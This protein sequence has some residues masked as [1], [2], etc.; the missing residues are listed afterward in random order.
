MA[1]N[2]FIC[3]HGH[4]YQ[5]PRENAW[6][7][8]IESQESAAPYHDWNSRIQDECYATNAAARVVDD[9]SQILDI[10]NNYKRISF[11][12]GP[13]LL[14]WMQESDPITYRRILEADKRSLDWG[15]GTAIAQSHSHLIMP[16]CNDRD[17]KTQIVWGIEDFKMRFGRLPQGMWLAETAVD[18]A[19]LEDLAELGI[20]FT[21]LAPRQC[22]GMKQI[23]HN[24]FNQVA[25]GQFDT[26]MPYRVNL[27]SGK[28]IAV[29]FYDGQISQKIAFEKLLDNGRSFGEMLLARFSDNDQPELVHVATDGETYGHHHRLGEMA[30]A[31]CLRHVEQSG[32][33]E[34]I[35]YAEFLTRFPPQFEAQI[36]EN[37]SWSCVHGVERWRSNCGCHTG[38]QPGWNQ[39]WRAPLRAA[40]DM[41]R[42]KLAAFYNHEAGLLLTDP[43][44]ARDSYIE[45]LSNRND[46][47]IAAFIARHTDRL[48]NN[49]ELVR[50]LRLLEMQRN[51]MYM[52]T[53]CGWFFNDI[54]GIETVQILQYACRAIEYAKLLH[55]PDIEDQ[56]LSLLATAHSNKP[57][58]GTAADLYK[59]EVM[60]ARALLEDFARH[61]AVAS[62]FE[63][64]PNKVK[65]YQYNCNIDRLELL[66]T[67]T[68]RL[69]L[70][71]VSITSALTHSTYKVG[72]A[73]L[74][75]GQLNLIGGI[76]DDIGDDM[77]A[78]LQQDMTQAYESNL[79]TVGFLQLFKKY[80][81]E[82]LFSFKHLFK[83]ERLKIMNLVTEEHYATV[84]NSMRKIYDR[85]YPLMSTL[86]Q[87]RTKVPATYTQAA[88]F[89][90]NR[91]LL[92][93]LDNLSLAVENFMRIRN[94]MTKWQVEVTEPEALAFAY[95]RYVWRQVERIQADPNTPGQVLNT[96]SEIMSVVQ[97]LKFKPDL[98]QAQ[99]LCVQM[100]KERLR[101]DVA[102]L[103]FCR[104]L[105]IQTEAFLE[106]TQTIRF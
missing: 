13:T 36:H 106:Q 69:S 83:D 100:L 71:R 37:S 105:N 94:E 14:S 80:F 87:S 7:E 57:E 33:A 50:V 65:L 70:G 32:R 58:V 96:L 23:G 24:D 15:Q 60:P 17:R 104:Q 27:P 98:W 35:S 74:Y 64:Y 29:F 79:D 81:G 88:G 73:V 34:I 40:L 54:S 6:L 103:Q 11:N 82:D 39:R 59:R 8:A 31:S 38:G 42:D 45:V 26:R 77:F 76:Y 41:L 5:P 66:G 53:S 21:I 72:F 12:F 2:K 4:F 63:T 43:W 86:R 55:G 67:G 49:E 95:N 89:V 10:T 102:F 46:N 30:L 99:N 84:E 19:T 92:R 9:K 56:F 85:D 75:N 16:L 47:S 97:T 48:L 22:K 44:K 78:S 52:Y 90:L 3:I 93:L 28:H 101:T 62:I 20:T 18:T 68:Y 25:E 51:A 61:F 91:D 1:R